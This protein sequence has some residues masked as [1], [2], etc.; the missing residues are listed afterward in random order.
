MM[1]VFPVSFS[2]HACSDYLQTCGHV[3]LNDSA[4]LHGHLAANGSSCVTVF[5]DWNTNS[6]LP[7]N[8][9]C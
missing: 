6:W 2:H 7:T 8:L 9:V 3:F 5:I 1:Q 4:E